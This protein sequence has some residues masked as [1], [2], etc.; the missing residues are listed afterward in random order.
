MY[1]F[2]NVLLSFAVLNWMRD[3]PAEPADFSPL[4]RGAKR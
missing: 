4:K 2:F 1:K 3:W